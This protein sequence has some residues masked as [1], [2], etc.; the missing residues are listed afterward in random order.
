MTPDLQKL[1]RFSLGIAL[2]LI[3]YSLAIVKLPPQIP[4]P[5]LG[6]ATVDR[7]WLPIGLVLA[8]LYGMIEFWFY[9]VRLSVSPW[10]GLKT[11]REGV[12]VSDLP[13]IAAAGTDEQSRAAWQVALAD[14]KRFF[15]SI[16]RD[17]I[18]LSG[19]GDGIEFKF[20]ESWKTTG[21][22]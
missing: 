22:G 20:S 14:I 13:V 3:T 21:F 9:G 12:T 10:E 5:L 8:S 19:T 1:R 4:I 17:D 2:V 15:P 16:D 6:D 7:T 11:L 18:E